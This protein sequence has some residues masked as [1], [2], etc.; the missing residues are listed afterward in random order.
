M[1]RTLG[2]INDEIIVTK[3]YG[4]KDKGV[5][6]QLT[7]QS[8]QGYVQLNASEIVAL[9][10]M[11]KE[12]LDGELASKHRE[13]KEAIE[14]YKELEKTIVKDMRDVSAMAMS[15]TTLDMS[16]LLCLGVAKVDGRE[17]H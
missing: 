16:S 1:S 8:G 10:P 7:S 17:E 9:L 13:C 11:L 14:Q 5:S 3:F 2:I 15:Q 12:V 4:G 6:I